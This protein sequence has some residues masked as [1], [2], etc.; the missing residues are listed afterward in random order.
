MKTRIVVD[1]YDASTLIKELTSAS[2]IAISFLKSL[3]E[4]LDKALKLKEEE[5]RLKEKEICSL[6]KIF[7]ESI[8]AICQLPEVQRS[9]AVETWKKSHREIEKH[10]KR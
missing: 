5:L 6:K 1:S 3:D 7:S 4:D 9:K 2:N 10:T 8:E